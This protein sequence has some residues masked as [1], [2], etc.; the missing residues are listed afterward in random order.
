MLLHCMLPSFT[1]VTQIIG[2]LIL[3]V[4][5]GAILAVGAKMISGDSYSNRIHKYS[6][7]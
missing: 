3:I 5:Y 7:K 1:I 4:F 6:Q 2:N